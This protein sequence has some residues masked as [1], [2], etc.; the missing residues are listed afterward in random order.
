MSLSAIGILSYLAPTLQ[1]LIAV[2]VYD[3]PLT[4]SHIICFGLI[5]FSLAIF[6]ADSIIAER[7][8]QVAVMTPA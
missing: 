5:W 7:K 4:T 8:R 6:S 3:E 1:F 2:F